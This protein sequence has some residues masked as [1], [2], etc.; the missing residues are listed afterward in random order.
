MMIN[1]GTA[2]LLSLKGNTGRVGVNVTSTDGASTTVSITL[3]QL[4]ELVAYGA[5]ILDNANHEGVS[6]S[7]YSNGDI[8]FH[9]ND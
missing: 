1:E 8:Q 3:A 7:Q 6:R 5:R 2:Q 9:I 4:K